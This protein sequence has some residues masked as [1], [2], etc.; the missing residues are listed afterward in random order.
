[1]S[2]LR[3]LLQR[4]DGQAAERQAEKLR[5]VASLNRSL[6]QD[7]RALQDMLARLTDLTR[8][9]QRRTDQLAA[10]RQADAAAGTALA[11]LSPLF[12]VARVAAHVQAAVAGGVLAG[13]PVPHLVMPDLLP[14]DA[15]AALREAI[16]P[17]LVFDE[18]AGEMAV[19]ALPLRLAPVASIVAWEFMTTA[20]V[21]PV[22]APAVAARFQLTGQPLAAERLVWCAT[23]SSVRPPRTPRGRLQAVVSLCASGQSPPLEVEIAPRE[24]AGD[25]PPHARRVVVPANAAVALLDGAVEYRAAPGGDGADPPC[26][27]EFELSF[28]HH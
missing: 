20:I 4:L 7:V 9:L 24:S 3:A 8:A 5:A 18:R 14:G 13:E 22:L 1:M 25:D 19:L 23:G 2:R 21:Q 28:D 15:Y 16:P 12:D 17:R 11:R 10:L 26:V 6:R 27:W